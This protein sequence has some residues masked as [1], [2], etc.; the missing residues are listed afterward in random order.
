MFVI[1]YLRITIFI[2]IKTKFFKEILSGFF[3][4]SSITLN[5]LL[6]IIID[7]T[8]F[9]ID[10][11]YNFLHNLNTGFIFSI[12]MLRSFLLSIKE[13]ITIQLFTTTDFTH[14]STKLTYSTT[15]HFINNILMNLTSLSIK[16]T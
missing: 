14:S 5:K 16:Y 3:N 6:F 9:F 4:V 13:L 1:S 10:I 11:I 8:I 15:I 12:Q 7:S 2:K